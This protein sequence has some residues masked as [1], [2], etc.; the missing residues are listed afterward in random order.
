MGLNIHAGKGMLRI[1]LVA[2]ENFGQPI[3]LKQRSRFEYRLT[4]RLSLYVEAIAG[5]TQRK[6]RIHYRPHCAAMICKRIVGWVVGRKRTYAP[7]RKHGQYRLD[8]SSLGV[9]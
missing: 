3:M 8:S 5:E 7:P 1:A 4:K 2:R 9:P 6:H